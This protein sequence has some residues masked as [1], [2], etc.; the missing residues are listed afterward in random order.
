MYRRFAS[1][2]ALVT[3]FALLPAI[4]LAQQ[5]VA[6]KL[7]WDHCAGDGYVGDRSFACDT[8]TG[9]ET[10]WLSMAIQDGVT[11]TNVGGFSAELDVRTTSSVLPPWWLMTTGQCRAGALSMLTG[12]PAAGGSCVLWWGT[13]GVEPL[14]V[15]QQLQGFEGLNHVRWSLG[16][17]L[18]AQ[19]SVT[20]TPG[21]EY[22]LTRLV[23]SHAK[24]TGIGACTG[25]LVPTCIGFGETDLYYSG[26]STV[27]RFAG[28]LSSTVTWQGAYVS[29][30]TPSPPHH[31]EW[32]H[33]IGVYG[34]NLQCA[35]GPV[36]A[37]NRTWGTIKTL[38]R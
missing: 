29:G 30:F 17:G 31:D 11:R 25:C 35:T 16:A 13:S 28:G 6:L 33:W 1:S 27:E 10:L 15:F 24:S 37:T 38:Y 36:P 3:A 34:G 19:S 12:P 4:A 23:I 21:T 2:A 14:W 20:L 9:S 26:T 5:G 7:S 22:L 8:N 18:P 32:G